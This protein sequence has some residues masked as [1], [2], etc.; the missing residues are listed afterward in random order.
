MKKIRIKER[1]QQAGIIGYM[2]LV[3]GSE[4]KI[5]EYFGVRGNHGIRES[6]ADDYCQLT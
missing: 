4:E 1:N 2:H 6:E 3:V 5:K